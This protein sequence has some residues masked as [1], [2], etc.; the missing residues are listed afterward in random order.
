M[1]VIERKLFVVKQDTWQIKLSPEP[2]A[3]H[4]RLSTASYSA[5]VSVNFPQQPKPATRQ[6]VNTRDVVQALEFKTKVRSRLL[7]LKT[8]PRP[9][10]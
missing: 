4:V 5:A 9:R 6:Q 8:K 3:V 7:G 2:A 1:A 10:L